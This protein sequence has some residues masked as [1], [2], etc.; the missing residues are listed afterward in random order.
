ME[1]K[2]IDPRVPDND[3]Q[4]DG[5]RT[6]RLTFKLNHTMPYTDEYNAVLKELF[7]DNL[8][9]GSTV[10]APLTLMLSRKV[11]IGKRVMNNCLMMS[12]GGITIEDDVMIAA[13]VQLITNNHDPYDRLLLHCKPVHICRGAWIG[14]GSSILP[15]LTVGEYAIVGAG[16]IVTK[17]VPP[18]AVVVGSPAK[19]VRYLDKNKFVEECMY[20]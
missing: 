16:S 11:K 6:A 5:M 12:A 2:I 1:E 7:P 8:G 10:M 19:V 14:A 18:Y 3:R 9:E 4:A 15:G 17:D 13:N 20:G